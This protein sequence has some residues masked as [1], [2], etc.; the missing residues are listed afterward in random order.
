MLLYLL[1]MELPL[2]A[3]PLVWLQAELWS[4]EKRVLVQGGLFDELLLPSPLHQQHGSSDG[5]H[6]PWMM[7]AGPLGLRPPLQSSA[8]PRIAGQT[9]SAL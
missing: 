6:L 8:R 2:E 5:L 7:D 3:E 1:G 4:S 9:Y